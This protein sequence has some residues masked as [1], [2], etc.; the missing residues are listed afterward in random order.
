MHL[1]YTS[2]LFVIYLFIWFISKPESLWYNM[3]FNSFYLNKSSSYIYLCLFFKLANQKNI[4][5]DAY[6]LTSW[7]RSLLISKKL[8]SSIPVYTV[9]SRLVPCI[10]AF[11]TSPSSNH[12]ENFIMLTLASYFNSIFIFTFLFFLLGQNVVFTF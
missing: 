3:Y 11:L 1:N 9:A 10:N 12:F 4:L 6:T 5:N 7:P 8:P 2:S